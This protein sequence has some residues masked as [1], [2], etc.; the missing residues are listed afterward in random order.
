MTTRLPQLGVPDPERNTS[1]ILE[2]QEERNPELDMENRV[3]HFNDAV[4]SVGDLVL[5]GAEVLRCDEG[6]VWVRQA[7]VRTDQ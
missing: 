4:Y 5:C 3:C 1:P 6:G 7:E 2:E